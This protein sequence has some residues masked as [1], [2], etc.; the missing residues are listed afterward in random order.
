[1]KKRKNEGEALLLLLIA[2]LVIVLLVGLLGPMIWEAV[3]SPGYKK[4][5]SQ[6]IGTGWGHDPNFP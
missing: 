4:P 2:A 3:S 1:M 5:L 6:D